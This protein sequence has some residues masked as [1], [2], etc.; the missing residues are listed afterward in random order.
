MTYLMYLN[1]YNIRQQEA[2]YLG[3]MFE[4][5]A[6]NSDTHFILS[7]EYLKDYT[8]EGRWEIKWANNH[9]GYDKIIKRLKPENYT[10]MRKP[11]EI[12]D[13]SKV[14]PSEI[15]HYVATYPIKEQ[16]EVIED[17]LK[18]KDIKAGI[19][20]V[21]NR[22]FEKTLERHHIPTIH[23]E[24]GPFRPP[25]YLPTIYTDFSGVNGNTEFNSRFKEF[26]KVCNEVPILSREEILKI[27]SPKHNSKL[28]EILHNKDYK[29]EIGVGLQ[30][31]VDTNLLLFS[32]GRHWVDPLLQAQADC[33]GKVLI[34][35]HPVAGY[36][37][38]PSARLDIDDLT[39]GKAIDFINKCKKIYCLNSS[40][41]LE[42]IL[43]GREARIFG[44]SP[45]A[46]LCS[47]NEDM[48]LK[49]LNFAVFGY[50]THRDLLFED[51]YYEWRIPAR[52]NEKEIYLRNMKTFVEY[53][54]K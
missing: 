5:L 46:S 26:L 47:M 1:N 8:S 10:V 37:M 36:L 22:C 31:E 2:Q 39:K 49:A 4:N 7:K 28:I 21:N 41:G 24:L 18:K 42:A 13:T 43:L 9:W 3:M 30:V 12:L 52:G 44:D 16:V 48:Q 34:R 32:K 33:T 40:V 51:S 6:H 25:I 17:V 23:H 54:K 20:W 11:E 14:V 38:K 27:I 35:P 15:L 45:F 50:L 19:T 29:Y 53:A